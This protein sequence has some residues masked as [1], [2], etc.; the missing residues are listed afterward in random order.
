MFINSVEALKI[1]NEDINIINTLN[2]ENDVYYKEIK[3]LQK[4]RNKYEDLNNDIIKHKQDLEINDNDETIILNNLKNIE[5]YYNE[6]IDDIV[7]KYKKLIKIQVK[8]SLKIGDIEMIYY[9][10]IFNKIN[11]IDFYN[12]KKHYEFLFKYILTDK[13]QILDFDDDYHIYSYDFKNPKCKNTMN[14][15]KYETLKN[16]IIKTKFDNNKSI[17][18]RFDMNITFTFYKHLDDYLKKNDRCLKS[19]I[20]EYYND[21]NKLN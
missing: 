8:N 18:N 16:E 9:K 2:L 17:Y 13:K 4:E 11:G 15:R 14:T 5:R 19:Y 3:N 6:K 20:I 10:E 12:N 21:I 7:E 1:S